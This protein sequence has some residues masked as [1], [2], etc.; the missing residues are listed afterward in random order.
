MNILWPDPGAW[1]LILCFGIWVSLDQSACLQ[2]MISQPLVASWI[3]GGIAGDPECGL[4]VGML[5]QGVWSRALPMG[6]SPLPFVGPAGV[7]GGVLAAVV[8]GGRWEL[9]PVLA[10]P[11]A[12]PLAVA[13]GVSIAIGETGRPL[14]SA[15]YRHRGILRSMAERGALEGRAGQIR[16]AHLAGMLP[17][18]LLGWVLIAAGLLLGGLLL[19]VT[20]A[21]PADGRWVALPVLGIGVGQAMSLSGFRFRTLGRRS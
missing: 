3:A 14:L 12:L 2:I 21:W 7:V 6:A 16:I 19:G 1:A 18:A 17:T 9:G 5:L 10:V 13:L 11:D 15:I 4:A 8:P 20:N